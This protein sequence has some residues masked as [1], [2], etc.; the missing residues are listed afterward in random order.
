MELVKGIIIPVLSDYVLSPEVYYGD[1]HRGIYFQTE[2]EQ[3]GRI[4][5]NNLDAIKIC[6]GENLPFA[7]DW[8]I[9]QEVAW[10]YK[11]ENSKWLKER[12]NY[13]ND[14]YGSS[15]EF[16][17]NVKEMLTD[18]S[19]YV[20]KFHDQFVEVIAK[21]FWFEKDSKSLFKKELKD[22]HPFLPLPEINVKKFEIEGVKCKAIFNPLDIDYLIQNTRYCQQKLIEFTIEF[23]GEYSVGQ[24][25]LMMQRQNRIVSV[26]SS[27]F[28]RLA[29]E[30]E[31][32]ATFEE[33]KPFV[34]KYIEEVAERRRQ[35]RN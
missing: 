1:K 11:I 26:L 27:S 24:T 30:K 9:G 29:F 6:R 35:R 5:F 23:K 12:F 21:G 3:F 2:D 14:N 10:V 17:G 13:E 32:V 15:Y 34:E 19:H 25:L 22:G 33:I 20:F 31:G 28:G 7:E 16:G 8:E 4:T 18:F